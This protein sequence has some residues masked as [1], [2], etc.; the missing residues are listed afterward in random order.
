MS[1]T[2][3]GER[4]ICLD[5]FPAEQ[6][7]RPL[8]WSTAAELPLWALLWRADGRELIFKS[9]EDVM[10]VRVQTGATI[11]FGTPARLFQKGG[12]TGLAVTRDGSRFLVGVRTTDALS[13]ITVIP[14]W[15]P[16][17]SK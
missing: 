7:C 4:Q 5:T 2:L 10:A 6:G 11:S 17:R 12:T 14:N 8:A 13:A 16:D 1:R 9:G 3:A 15:A